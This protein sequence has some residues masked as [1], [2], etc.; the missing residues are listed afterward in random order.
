MRDEICSRCKVKLDFTLC[1]LAKLFIRQ[2]KERTI[3]II[4]LSEQLKSKL[5]FHS[6]NSI[7]RSLF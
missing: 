1:L 5:H 3:H 2:N 6:T 7:K 4:A